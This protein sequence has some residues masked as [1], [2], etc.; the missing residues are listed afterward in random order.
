MCVHTLVSVVIGSKP[1]V[2]KGEKSML[3]TV[4]T[5]GTQEDSCESASHHGA[6]NC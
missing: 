5:L 6:F 4:L 1:Q 3:M 2:Y